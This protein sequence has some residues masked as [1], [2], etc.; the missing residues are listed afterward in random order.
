M[1]LGKTIPISLPRYAIVCPIISRLLLFQDVGIAYEITI[2]RNIPAALYL[3]HKIYYPFFR[4]FSLAS[5]SLLNEISIEKLSLSVWSHRGPLFI[6]R[7]KK[8]EQ[9]LL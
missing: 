4:R 1:I 3:S 5:T 2:F 7:S 6:P 9:I 8:I